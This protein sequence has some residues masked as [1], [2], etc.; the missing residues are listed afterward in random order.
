MGEDFA[1]IGQ[2]PQLQVCEQ[3]IV[4]THR[5][6]LKLSCLSLNISHHS[7][8]S[9]SL[10][11]FSPEMDNAPSL[12]PS[13]LPSITPASSHSAARVGLQSANST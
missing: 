2:R 9:L 10:C 7:H 4:S 1:L 12:H 8:K 13:I 5:W 6:N 11:C 3:L